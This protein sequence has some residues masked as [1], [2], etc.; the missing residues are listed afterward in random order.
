MLT[1]AQRAEHAGRNPL[2]IAVAKV[3]KALAGRKLPAKRGRPAT[4]QA[5]QAARQRERLRNKIAA[6]FEQDQ[7][8]H[9]VG[10]RPA[11][12]AKPRQNL[13]RVG[14]RDGRKGAGAAFASVLQAACADGRRQQR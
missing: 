5:K 7:R 9:A 4:P 6:L 2:G 13:R 1:Q 14:V 10:R 11:P 12:A 3:R 8:E